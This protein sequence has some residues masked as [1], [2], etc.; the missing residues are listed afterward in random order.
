M[1]F[2][3]KDI[4]QIRK[5]VGLTQGQLANLSGVSQSLIA[6]IEAG[7]ID[8]TYSNA[9]K[10]FTALNELS[11]KQDIKAEKLMTSKIIS[12]ASN[13]SIKDAIKKMVRRLGIY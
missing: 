3:L 6:K 10:I 5:K 7:R 11:K 9:K 8:P 1:P 4:K 13:D 12:V 2:N